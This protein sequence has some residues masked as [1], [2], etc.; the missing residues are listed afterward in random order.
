MKHIYLYGSKKYDFLIEGCE[1]KQ[2]I[3][4]KKFDKIEENNLIIIRETDTKD[5]VDFFNYIQKT[6]KQVVL[7]ILTKQ[8]TPIEFNNLNQKNINIH[9]EEGDESKLIE[10][11]KES[12]EEVEKKIYVQESE[13]RDI[14]ENVGDIKHDFSDYFKKVIEIKIKQNS[15]LNKL[16]QNQSDFLKELPKIQEFEKNLDLLML[17]TINKYTISAIE[18][19]KYNI[20]KISMIFLQNK[21][22]K[23]M[24]EVLKN[25]VLVLEKIEVLE[26]VEDIDLTMCNLLKE[27][28][29]RFI[30]NIIIEGNT[31]HFNYLTDSYQSTIEVLENKVLNKDIE[32][33]E[34]E[35]EFFF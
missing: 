14:I 12:I 11:I 5:F 34:E 20:N 1:I 30:I 15:F 29:S 16:Q 6:Y 22:L 3:E 9:M 19:Y 21:E 33:S 27:D 4:Y 26:E 18:E 2:S 24:G 31:E 35:D 10:K 23:N 17:N 7:L 28:L 8:K 25:Y 13:K 32:Y